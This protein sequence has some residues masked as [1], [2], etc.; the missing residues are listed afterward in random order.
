MS[1]WCDDIRSATADLKAV[2]VLAGAT[3]PEGIPEIEFQPS[4]HKPPSRLPAGK[5]AVYAFYWNGVWLKIGAAGPKSNARYTS[6]HYSAGSAPSTLA[7]SLLKDTDFC[8]LHPTANGDMRSWVKTNANRVNILFDASL[9]G[10]ILLLAETF[11]HVRLK[12]KYERNRV[13]QEQV[14]T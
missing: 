2:C 10:G 6:Q 7:G 4:P 8:A 3:L 5:M 11:L 14:T 1:D 9:G 12:P 13:K